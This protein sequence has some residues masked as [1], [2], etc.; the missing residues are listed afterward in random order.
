MS[1][2]EIAEAVEHAKAIVEAPSRSMAK[3]LACV[4]EL[5]LAKA[6]LSAVERLGVAKDY[7]EDVSGLDCENAAY[8]MGEKIHCYKCTTCRAR[9]ALDGIGGEK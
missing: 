7:I 9:S 5:T 1:N 4:H 3:R 2:D 8:G 6:L